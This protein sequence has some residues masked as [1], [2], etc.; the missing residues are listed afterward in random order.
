MRRP[1]AAP[2]SKDRGAFERIFGS[3]P[4]LRAEAPARINLLGE[5]TD[6]NDGFVLPM[7]LPYYTSV[8]AAPAD[9]IVEAYA[10]SFRE[11]H[12]RHAGGRR[13][14]T[15][16]D[17]VAGCVETLRQAGR[18]APGARVYIEST[19]PPGAGLASSAA[20]EVAV[21]RALNALYE[22]GMTDLEIAMAA[23][24]TES[25]YVGVRCGVM[26]QTVVSVGTVGEALLL[27]TRS[28][29]YEPVAIP[30][31]YRFAVVHSGIPRRLADAGY[32][33]RRSECEQAAA[34]VGVPAL[35][36]LSVDDLPK[37]D[38]L[39]E[40]LNRRARHVIRE[41]ARTVAGAGALRRREM[42]AF[43]RLMD[44]SHRSLRD[45]YEVSLPALDRL[46]ALAGEHGALGARLTGAGFGGCIVALIPADAMQNF[47]KEIYAGYS[48]AMLY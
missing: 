8:D 38:S 3:R 13:E 17:Y 7:P 30:D 9:G 41:N 43:G 22:L 35:R 12:V 39:P 28:L 24:R 20:L 15:W 23:H 6:Y 33:Q 25:E 5:H 48:G 29:R 34:A 40:P 26:D 46:V 45:D 27:D 14:G 31:A 16:M 47:E 2:G 1:P 44:E 18:E 37:V 32:N 21:L 11:R 4:V 42:A 36:D 19:I 10:E